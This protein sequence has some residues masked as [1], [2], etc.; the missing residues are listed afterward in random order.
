MKIYKKINV[1]D[2]A[3]NRVRF[4]FEEFDNV[5]V[6]FSGGKD[7]TVVL[8]LALQVA[9]EQ[10][11]LPLKVMFIDQEAE[12]QNVIDYMHTIMEDERVDP[13]WMQI[14]F[15]IFNST[16]NKNQWITAW[17]HG[18]E[19][20]R[21]YVDY[22][23]KENN[24]G[25]DRFYELYNAIF[26]KE[27]P[28]TRSCLLGGVRSEES[29][30]RHVAMTQDATYKW[31]TWGKKLNPKLDH[32][33]FYPIYDWSYTDVWKAIHDEQWPYCKIYDYQYMYGVNIR[34]MRVSNLHHETA[35]ESLFYLQDIEQ[36]TW[37][38]LTKRMS[39]ISTAG[40]LSKKDYFIKELPFMFKD[41][42]E[43]RDYLTEKLIDKEKDR[44]RCIKKWKALDK[45]YKNLNGKDKL[46]KTMINS[47]LS[48]DYHDFVKIRNFTERPELM[49]WRKHNET[50]IE[51]KYTINN[52][53]IK[54]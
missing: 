37:N 44:E 14:P 53:W 47:I 15:K 22:S 27:F 50:G 1:F 28:E 8:N 13:M 31:I 26:K 51:N 43:Y 32:Y 21:P 12:W 6:G 35:I 18:A 11:R 3:L 10:N 30:R 34:N 40:K 33:T 54:R 7:S 2:E 39:G 29:P 17:E 20:M 5:V 4:L 25:T 19:H 38:A 41:W 45:Q 36:D 23:I 46:T 9:E 42:E 16:S 49:W 52:K 48:N 24:Y